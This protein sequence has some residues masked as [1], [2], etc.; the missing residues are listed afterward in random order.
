[1]VANLKDPME[2]LS[3]WWNAGVERWF[4]KN[5]EFDLQI[6]D[7]FTNTYEAAEKGELDHW[8]ESPHSAMALLILLD[9]FP[10]NMFRDSPRAFATDEKALSIAQ[11][12]LDKNYYLAYPAN[13]RSFYFLP[14]EHSEEM[15]AQ[16]ISVEY[17]RK[18]GDT[19][20]HLYALIHMDIIRRFGRFP[21]RN[22]TLGRE[23]TEAELEFLSSGGFSGQ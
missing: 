13:I 4:V 6:V 20:G 10:R 21:H 14:F 5:D 23:S 1:M 2:I 17:F 9:Q 16:D 7:N 11:T 15:W 22:K 18:F 8:I 3:F 19:D 12:T